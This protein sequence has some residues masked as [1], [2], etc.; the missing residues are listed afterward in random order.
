MSR[1]AVVLVMALLG[2]YALDATAEPLVLILSPERTRLTFTV[3]AT[4]HVIEGLLALQSGE[5]HF[6]PETGEASGQVLIDLRRAITG[7]RLRDHEM[8]TSVLETEQY[9]IA[10]FRPSRVTG[11]F[12][13]SGPSELALAGVL[14]L[15]GVEH[16]MILPV[17]VK[18]TGETV[19]AETVFEVPYVAWGLHN[20]SLLFLRVAPI[21]AV[22][23]RTEASLHLGEKPR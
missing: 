7:N 16:S 17:R 21:A 15:H 8:H 5:I 6:D 19:S 2:L 11:S 1:T 23:L 18:A 9:P 20:P 12:V 10:T 13:P 14:S 4:G 22:S 3:G